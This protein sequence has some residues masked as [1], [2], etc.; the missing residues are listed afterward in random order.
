MEEKAQNLRFP[1]L[2]ESMFH[3]SRSPK[4]FIWENETCESLF[5]FVIAWQKLTINSHNVP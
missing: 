4:A 3:F 1:V 2:K 5:R